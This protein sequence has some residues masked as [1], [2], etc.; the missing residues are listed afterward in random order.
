MVVVQI[1]E[2]HSSILLYWRSIVVER[3]LMKE[4]V[5]KLRDE[6]GLFIQI[7][8]TFMNTEFL[9]WFLA[10]GGIMILGWFAGRSSR[11]SS[12]Y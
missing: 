11:K 6:N 12:H 9:L 3:D 5:R 8:S 1:G 7:R 4:Q 10:G 2:I